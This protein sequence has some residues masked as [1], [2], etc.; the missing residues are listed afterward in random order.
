MSTEAIVLSY[1]QLFKK[2]NGTCDGLL[3]HRPVPVNVT[4]LATHL[5]NLILPINNYLHYCA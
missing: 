4:A 3:E 1:W 5:S 2:L